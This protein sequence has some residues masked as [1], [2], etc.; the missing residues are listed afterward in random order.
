MINTR[1]VS[2]KTK[3]P[4]VVAIIYFDLNISQSLMDVTS[5]IHRIKHLSP[6]SP[7]TKMDSCNYIASKP[8][9]SVTVLSAYPI[10]FAL[11]L[12]KPTEL[13]LLNSY[14]IFSTQ[15]TARRAHTRKQDTVQSETKLRNDINRLSELVK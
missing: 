12:F 15:A 2:H 1:L 7:M 14:S 4:R 10:S 6:F 3:S 5:H 8:T 11:K 13:G 9:G